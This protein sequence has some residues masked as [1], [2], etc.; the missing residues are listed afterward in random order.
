MKMD[1]NKK[2]SPVRPDTLAALQK[3]ERH[4]TLPPLA[5]D[6]RSATGFA[7]IL[8]RGNNPPDVFSPLGSVLEADM[9]ASRGNVPP[10]RPMP[11][12]DTPPEIPE[13]KMLEDRRDNPSVAATSGFASKNKALLTASSS[14]PHDWYRLAVPLMLVTGSLLMLIGLWAI[15]SLAGLPNVLVPHNHDS[16]RYHTIISLAWKSLVA[17]PIGLMLDAMAVFMLYRLHGKK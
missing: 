3:L 7:A 12:N 9:K 6:P 1:K 8:A 11:R 15:A 16:S 5:E 4:E 14:K 10:P 13:A 17:L 2:K